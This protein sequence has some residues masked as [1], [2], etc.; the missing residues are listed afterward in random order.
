MPDFLT[1][2]WDDEPGGNVEHLAEHGVTPEEAEQAANSKALRLKARSMALGM[3][4][5]LTKSMSG[6][7]VV[8]TMDCT[9]NALK[10][11]SQPRMAE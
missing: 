8:S 4:D 6:R 10:R 7:S 3:F 1:I 11:M 2:L 9:P 5:I